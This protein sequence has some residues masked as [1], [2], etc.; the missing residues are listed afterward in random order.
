MKTINQSQRL[1]FNKL[2]QMGYNNKHLNFLKLNLYQWNIDETVQYYEN[3]KYCW[4]YIVNAECFKRGRGHG[5]NKKCLLIHN[6]NMRLFQLMNNGNIQK[7]LYSIQNIYVN[8]YY[9]IININ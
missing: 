9:V 7:Y 8:I 3:D 5:D 1:L 6:G 4:D 2:C